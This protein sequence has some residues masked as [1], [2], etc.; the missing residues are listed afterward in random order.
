MEISDR[1][2]ADVLVVTVKGRMDQMTSEHAQAKL[3]DYVKAAENGFAMVLDF[4]GL[5]YISSVG[6]RA[7]MLTAKESK[8]KNGRVVIAALTPV[9]QEI[10]QISRFTF[11]FKTFESVMSA[12][13]TLSP[14]A[15]DLYDRK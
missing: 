10:F 6:L 5:E 9:V 11:V 2:V 13:G 4:S 7:L 15:A 14:T 8:P 12:L 3:L 1:K